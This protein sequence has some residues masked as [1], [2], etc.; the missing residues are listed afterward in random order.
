MAA[1][2]EVKTSDSCLA[3]RF[4][5]GDDGC[6]DEVL[7]EI[8]PLICNG[9][10]RVFRSALVRNEIERI[11]AE[12]LDHARDNREKFNPAKGTL[13][14]WL[15][16]IAYNAVLDF[17]RS[18]EKT[19]IEL[20]FDPDKLWRFVKHRGGTADGAAALNDARLT[21]D[22][23]VHRS[24]AA[25]SA[26]QRLVLLAAPAVT[27][28]VI[29]D[30]ELADELGVTESTIRSHRRRG[31]LVL[32]EVLLDLGIGEFLNVQRPNVYTNRERQ[33]K[34]RR[35]RSFSDS[36]GETGG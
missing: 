30:R 24:L 28:A 33:P 14:G 34:E 19:P 13:A 12:A 21:R 36:G 10:R 3:E 11:V 35:C 27:D 2:V 22:A 31:K 32:R 18:R 15:W 6:L 23:L 16:S 5:R 29:S 8:C 4:R 20:S 7:R 26:P 17:L 25:L 9:L 1:D